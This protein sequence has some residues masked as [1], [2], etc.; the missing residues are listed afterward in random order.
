MS[1]ILVIGETEEGDLTAATRELLGAAN[2]LA[3]ELGGEV[4]LALLGA[5]L[6]A[7]SEA[8]GP[9]GASTVYRADDASLAQYQTDA[10]LPL[11]QQIVEAGFAAGRV[12]GAEQHGARSRAAAGYATGQRRRD[13]RAGSQR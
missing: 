6:A 2:R 8:A 4:G 13:G 7:A 12:A 3:G 1:T 11:A 9:A 5:D 10:C